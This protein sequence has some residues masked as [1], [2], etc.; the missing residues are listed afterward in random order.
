[1]L[2]IAACSYHPTGRLLLRVSFFLSPATFF[3]FLLLLQVTI[4]DGA[5]AAY[6]VSGSTWVGFDLPQTIYMKILAA[7]QLGLGGLMVR[8]AR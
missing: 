1:M 8:C 4:H 5:K 7:R 6:L 2:L 3:F